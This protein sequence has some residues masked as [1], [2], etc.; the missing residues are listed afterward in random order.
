MYFRYRFSCDAARGIKDLEA[1]TGVPA[2]LLKHLQGESREVQ[3]SN[4]DKVCEA[5]T[6]A[7]E[8]ILERSRN[9]V[10][11]GQMAPRDPDQRMA[12]F[13]EIYETSK[14]KKTRTSIKNVL[15]DCLQLHV[16]IIVDA[17][18]VSESFIT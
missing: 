1:S 16:N 17:W 7:H 4:R 6:D 15:K 8:Y 14:G 2:L 3:M 18:E 12:D 9:K 13:K 10:E 11:N 5:F